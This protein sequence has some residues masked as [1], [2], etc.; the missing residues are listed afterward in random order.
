MKASLIFVIDYFVQF[1][2]QE[3]MTALIEIL[4]LFPSGY[5]QALL[6]NAS[7]ISLTYWLLWKKLGPRLKAWRIPTKERFNNQQ[8]RHEIKNAFFT[9]MVGALF[10][11]IV[12]Y[13][14]TQGYTQIYSTFGKHPI[15]SI[16]CFFVLLFI[17][18]AWF[19]S[20]HRLLHHPKLYRLIHE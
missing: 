19:Y 17:D 15:W 8:M 4:S 9:L 7:I 3:T 6:I 11:S 10:S 5:A 14:S 2:I 1:I 18:D 12:I 13:A 20:M 16:A